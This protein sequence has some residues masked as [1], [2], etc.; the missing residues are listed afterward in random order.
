M[1]SYGKVHFARQIF[2]KTTLTVERTKFVL[3]GTTVL[4]LCYIIWFYRTASSRITWICPNARHSAA[5]YVWSPLFFESWWVSFHP[6]TSTDMRNCP[7]VGCI[8]YSVVPVSNTPV[9]HPNNSSRVKIQV[10]KTSFTSIKRG[11]KVLP[12]TI[13]KHEGTNCLS[14]SIYTVSGWNI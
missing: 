3:W 2:R 10:T 8:T 4:I 6:V 11:Q 1:H 13:W 5:K 7:K 9:H 14:S 12:H